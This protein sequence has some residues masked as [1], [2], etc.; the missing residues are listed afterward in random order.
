M[1]R[2]TITS[3]ETFRIT[4]NC[5]SSNHHKSIMIKLLVGTNIK[6]LVS[7]SNNFMNLDRFML[8]IKTPKNILSLI[9]IAKLHNKI[10]LILEA[11]S[12]ETSNTISIIGNQMN[13]LK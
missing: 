12:I 8:K 6:D 1:A 10:H 7:Q 13:I 5:I 9:F 11:V 4:L 3:Q 2:I